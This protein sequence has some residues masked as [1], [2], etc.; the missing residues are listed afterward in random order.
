L[1]GPAENVGVFEVFDPATGDWR[2]LAP[3]PEAR[4]GAGLAFAGGTLVSVGGESTERTFDLVFGYEL[5][6]GRWRELPDL[7]TPRHGLAVAAVGN[8]V[9][10]IGGSPAADLG[11]SIANE[12]LELAP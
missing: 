12:Y 7:P 3:I 8:R 4:S 9:Y 11:F 6:T 5:A 10:A 2:M 1:G